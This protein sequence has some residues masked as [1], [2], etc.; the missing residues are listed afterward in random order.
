MANRAVFVDRDGT[1]NV[2]YGYI[3]SPDEFKMYPN[4][5]KGLR[6]LHEKGFKIIVI[7]NQSGIARGYFS[8]EKLDVI[9]N[10]MKDELS[11]EN[12]EVDAIYFCPHHPDEKCNCRKPQPGLLQQAIKDFDIDIGKSFFIG[13]RMLDVEAGRKVGCKTVLIPEDKKLV[14]KEMR[15]S[16]E[17]PDYIGDDFY[18][19]ALWITEEAE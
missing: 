3:S 14:E 9:H 8:K 19:G 1:I 17:E 11:Q 4:V 12:V 6:L 13:D 5:A 2:N 15:E 16:N 18:T 7:T 10:K